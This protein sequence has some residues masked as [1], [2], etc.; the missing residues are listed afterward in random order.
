MKMQMMKELAIRF[1]I[2]GVSP[3]GF[4]TLGEPEVI[5]VPTLWNM[6]APMPLVSI[7][8]GL[9]GTVVGL[10]PVGLSRVMP[11]IPEQIREYGR[12]EVWNAFVRAVSDDTTKQTSIV[13]RNYVSFK[14]LESKPIG[15]AKMPEELANIRAMLNMAYNSIS[16]ILKDV[17]N[18]MLLNTY[19]AFLQEYL[20][21]DTKKHSLYK[22]GFSNMTEEQWR[23][24]LLGK[25]GKMGLDYNKMI[26]I[27][28]RL[29]ELRKRIRSKRLREIEYKA[30][31]L[32]T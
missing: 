3:I 29:Y 14:L 5:D 20:Y 7:Y 13:V 27:M 21:G 31:K 4:V 32:L 2:V 17:D 9:G 23:E 18:A 22:H 16:D 12:V 11:R 25:Y 19:R 26:E 30:P 28:N 15:Q 10:F 6:Y 8:D 1:F 24:Y